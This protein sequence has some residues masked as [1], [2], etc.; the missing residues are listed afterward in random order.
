MDS[1]RLNIDRSPLPPLME[2][3]VGFVYAKQNGPVRGERYMVIVAVR[4]N[5]AYLLTF[6]AEGEIQNATQYCLRYL[7]ERRPVGRLA[8]MPQLEV[9]WFE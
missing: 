4:M 8:S 6:S 7:Q 9:D 2:P 3:E 5:T 1:M